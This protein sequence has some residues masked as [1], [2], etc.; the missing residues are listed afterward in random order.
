MNNINNN[1]DNIQK[2]NQKLNN[3]KILGRKR[4]KEEE[5][6]YDNEIYNDIEF[7][8][9]LLKEFLINNSNELDNSNN[10]EDRYDLTMKYLMNKK[11]KKKKNVD[12]KASKNRKIRYEKHEKLIN[13]MT[14]QIND[15]EIN[16]REIILNSLFGMNNK[17]NKKTEIINDI[18]II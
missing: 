8:N 12:T 17:N 11:L 10:V 4:M 1:Y 15:K 13:F 5:Y 18:D 6:N 3:E 16:G 14:P 7:Y 9:Y 2:N